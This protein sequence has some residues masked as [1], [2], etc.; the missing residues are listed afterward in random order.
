MTF[1][2]VERCEAQPVAAQVLQAGGERQGRR[3]DRRRCRVP[4]ETKPQG[5]QPM[6]QVCQLLKTNKGHN[7]SHTP[8]LKH[9]FK[10]IEYSLQIT[11]LLHGFEGEKFSS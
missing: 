8:T 7:F 3:L 2:C 1:L 5:K 6:D 11:D 4:Q 10:K 9:C